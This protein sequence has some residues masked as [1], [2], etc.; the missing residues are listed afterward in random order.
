MP[1]V[2]PV[3]QLSSQPA[4]HVSNSLVFPSWLNFRGYLL[5][6][7]E[8]TILFF[9]PPVGQEAELGFQVTKTKQVIQQSEDICY[10]L[11]PY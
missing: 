2:F 6:L 4:Q 1:D 8:A 3:P 9:P 11:K 10:N 5:P 7:I